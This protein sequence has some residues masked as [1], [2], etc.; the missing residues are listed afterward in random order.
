MNIL[1]FDIDGTL[2]D[3]GGAG[4]LAMESALLAEFGITVSDRHVPYA[5]RTDAAI[6]GD[7]LRVHELDVTPENI[8][9]FLV[10][11]L[12]HLPVCLTQRQGQALPG[13]RLLLE[14]LQ[15]RSDVLLGL[16][17]GNVEAGATNKLRHFGL[18]HFFQ[19]GGFADNLVERNDVA[20]V[21]RQRAEQYLGRE[22]DETI[23]LWVIGDTPHDV[24]CGRAIGARV[25]AVA[26]GSHSVDQLKTAEPDHVV[27]D[28]TDTDQLLALWVK[29]AN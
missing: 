4:K 26:T 21:A 11:Y 5:G 18:N 9:R 17:T 28:L 13:V 23:T 24:T 8:K 29:R 20:R 1:F 12:G 16:L 3:S 14:A 15:G 19:C 7:L 25:L 10:A 27:S 22:I 2:I 6:I